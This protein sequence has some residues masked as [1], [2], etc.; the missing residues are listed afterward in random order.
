MQIYV[1]NQDQRSYKWLDSHYFVHKSQEYFY[2]W[3]IRMFSHFGRKRV[4]PFYTNPTAQVSVEVRIWRLVFARRYIGI[5][6][7]DTLTE[8][9]MFFFL[10]QAISRITPRLVHYNILPNISSSCIQL[11]ALAVRLLTSIR[12]LLGSSLG[13][14]TRYP[15]WSFSWFASVLPDTFWDRLDHSRFLP[16]IFKCII[17][18]SS[19]HYMLHRLATENLA[20]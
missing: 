2:E 12:K 15:A 17:H 18:L 4:T 6:D 10:P 3:D 16:N 1:K 11:V 14:D 5:L 19:N 9:F 8:V 20:I 13:R 7:L